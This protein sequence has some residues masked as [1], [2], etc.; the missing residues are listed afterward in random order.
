MA[1]GS[2][3]DAKFLSKLGTLLP[4]DREGEGGQEGGVWGEGL[5][6]SQGRRVCE[7]RPLELGCV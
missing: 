4:S 7:Y 5:D 3:L 2:F 1:R 6:Q